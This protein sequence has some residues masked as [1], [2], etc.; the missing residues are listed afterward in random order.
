VARQALE[1]AYKTARNYAALADLALA[2][3][4]E[5]PDPHAKVRAYERLAFIDGELRG[6]AESARLGYESIIEVDHAHHPAMRVLEKHYLSEQ[7]WAELVALYEQMGLTAQDPAFAVAVHLDRARLRRRVGLPGNAAEVEAAVDNDYRLA[8]FKDRR[9]R[10]A[11]R[12]VYAR[13]RAAHDLFQM[14]DMAAALADAVGDDTRTA[15]V[16]LT[17]AAEALVENDHAEDARTR[18][19]QA[20]ERMPMHLPALVG[21]SDFALA[22]GDFA[23]AVQATERTG[24]VLR[25]PAARAH[26]WLV[27]G[28]LA[29]EK[30]GER[31]RAVEDLR[32]ALAADPR[33]H[34]AF[35]RLEHLYR[36]LS[37]WSALATLY[38]ERLQVETD[39][40]RLMALH[41]L[42]ARI[43]RDELK[44]RDRARA[45]LKSVLSQEGAHPEALQAL[46]DLQFEDQHWPEAAE[47][48]IRRARAEKSRI[49]LK[50]I[51]F[52]LGIIYSEH[53][54]D[55]KRAVAAFTRVLQVTPDDV[56]ALEHLSSLHLKEWEWK[57][58]LQATMR[59]A[60]LERDRHKRI[61]HLHRIAK[62]YEEGFK[63]ARHALDALRRALEID[64]MY[65]VSIGEL[66]KFFDRQSDVQ[67]MRVHLDRAGARVRQML[68]QNPYDANAYHSLFKIFLWRRAPD[69]A[70][71]TAGVLDWLGELESDERAQLQKLTSREN[72]PGSALADLTL[73]ETL[74]D[75]R[76]PAGFRNLF[77]LLDDALGKMFR[78]DVKRLGVQRSEKLPRAGHAL[79]DLANRVAA[80][81]GV[82]DFDLYVT[83]AH[84]TAL[85]VELTDPLSVVIGNR[86]IEGA[87]EQELRFLLGRCFKMIQSH[88]A[89]PMRLTPDDLGLLVGGIVRQFVP[90]FVP[91]GF[92]EAQVVAEAGR[93]ARIIPKKMHSE[94]LP[95][96]LECAS[97]SLDLKQIGP[98]LVHTANRAGLLACGL[99]GPALNA[100]RRLQDEAQLRALLRFSVS[101]ELAELRRQLG[102]SIG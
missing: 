85:V 24:Q 35:S 101:E 44:D 89:L 52:K 83:A 26:Y 99:P 12:H 90:D 7:A 77:R 22:K 45:E 59:L 42:L 39:G 96:A 41:L 91:Q 60:E 16:M 95:F 36:E 15:A 18:F 65:M 19:Q 1:R 67:S 72:Y 68:D 49:A 20:L 63:D 102:T 6:E 73:D 81:L 78:A 55:P 40:T 2:D 37:D 13:A 56:V 47:T 66:A 93:M 58:A 43:F 38:Q 50:D 3:L 98:S 84:P 75:A 46:A 10:P 71:I 30:L 62:I 34:E 80:D 51:F 86:V 79:R 23:L 8:L 82:R 21:L 61:V 69:R 28:T 97:Q 29:Q 33:S 94:L 74:F 27:A 57:G 25:D 11:L 70:A 87:H 54:P 9:A 31:G 5:A 32:Q 4:K 17:R 14:A 48:L 53:L 76:V 64:P 100:V 92:D 88:M